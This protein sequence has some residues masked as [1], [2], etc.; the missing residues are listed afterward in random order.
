MDRK[1]AEYIHERDF[2]A[3]EEGQ[4]I[5]IGGIEVEMVPVD[6]SLPGSCGFIIYTDEGNIVYTGDL[7]FH[8]SNGHLSQRFVEKARE[9]A[10]KWMLCEGTRMDSTDKD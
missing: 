5:S 4:R 2:H 8:G 10:P 1:R 6:H 7:R 3:M 9:S